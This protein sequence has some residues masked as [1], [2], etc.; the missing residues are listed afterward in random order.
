M[1]VIIERESVCMGDD[2][3]ASHTRKYN[4]NNDATYIDLFEAIKID[5]YLPSMSNV[6]WV[7]TNEHCSCIFSYFSKT[8]KLSMRLTEKYLKNICKNPNKFR[9]E[10]YPSPQRWKEH[11]YHMYNN[12]EYAIRKDGWYEEIKYC[13]YLMTL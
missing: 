13:D 12:D 3:L 10:Y 4:L 9:F 7:L 6:V 1:K 2:C 11:I 8:E 5:N